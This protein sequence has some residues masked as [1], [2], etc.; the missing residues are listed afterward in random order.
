M[1][2]TS[3]AFENRD[4]ALKNNPELSARYLN[5]NGMWK[6]NWVESPEK[7]PADF[8][9]TDFDDSK[10]GSLAVPAN[11]EFNG[12][13]IPIYLDEAYEFT[14]DPNPPDIP[15]NYNPVGSYRRKFNLPGDW[16]G[17]K[18]YIHV[19][20]FKS[21]FYIW[22]N[23]KFAGYSEDGKMEAEFDITPFLVPGENLIAMEGYRWSDGSYLECQDMWRVSGITRDVYLF[24]RPEIDIWDFNSTATLDEGYKNGLFSID[25]E[26]FNNLKNKTGNYFA[27]VEIIDDA[28][29][30]VYSEKKNINETVDKYRYNKLI[31]FNYI[32][33]GKN[34]FREYS[35][36]MKKKVV[37]FKAVI[38]NVKKWS[39][40]IPNLYKIG[41]AHV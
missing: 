39:A 23:G 25:L 29:K 6:F 37:N 31:L 2:A 4:L 27:S 11:W 5:L 28:G 3:F 16:N 18:I 34:D 33:Y 26:L 15:D 10:W 8:Y 7:R 20:A 9:K 36:E 12:Y 40:E 21:A 35:E 41:R 19:G 38:P 24:A 14:N 13:G 30:T 17:N 22:V 32:R 1:R